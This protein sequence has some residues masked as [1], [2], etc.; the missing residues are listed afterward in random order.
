M[1]M[2]KPR[3]RPQLNLRLAHVYDDGAGIPPDHWSHRFYE[4]I[5]CAFHEEDFADLYEEGGRAP[6]SPTLLACLSLLQ[7]M[8]KVSDRVAV[9]NS[10]MRRD[11]RIALGRLPEYEGFDPSVLCTFRRRLV[12]HEAQRQ[13]FE[14]V[15]QRVQELGLLKGHHRVRVD[16]TE[17]LAD[18]AV[19][20]RADMLREALRLVVCDLA[21]ARPKL[22]R[23]LDFRHLYEQYGAEVWL[24]GGHESDQKVSDLAR[25]GQLLLRLCGP[26]EVAGKETLARLLEENFLFP[27]DQ[28]PIPKPLAELPPDHIAT[29]HE[30][31]AEVGKNDRKIWT[32]DKVHI[33]ET[34]GPGGEPGFVLDVLTTGPRVP[35]AVLLP[36][37]MER[38]RFRFPAVET[39]LAD[40]GYAS[41]ANSKQA[42]ALG[43]DL[44]SPPRLDNTKGILPASAFAFDF[45]RQVATC[46][47]GQ[48][49][50]GWR[51]GRKLHIKFSRPVCRAC[52]RRGECTTSPSEPRTLTLSADYEQL[53]SDRERARRPAFAK[54]YRPRAGVEGTISELVHRCG[55]RRSR[56]R[57]RP[58]RALHSLLSSA[59][60]NVRRLLRAL[61]AGGGPEGAPFRVFS[62]LWGLLRGGFWARPVTSG[63]VLA[64]A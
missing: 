17:L 14:K 54:L 18:V 49:S 55:L 28:D 12:A 30:P 26:Y 34:I 22:R 13:L 56:Y 29:P 51:V 20:S 1:P 10:L 9:D 45:E 52:P 31:D 24:G 32:G 43:L 2:A 27:E 64:A 21:R 5:Y 8:Y 4:Q 60:L 63:G 15:L 40:S 57:S 35:D 58:K 37:I 11:W 16:A 39:I 6:I 44:I 38:L 62:A 59:A 25:D 19:L 46:P 36:E 61:A 47:A 23:R 41:A 42:A 7:Y 33:V 53:L 3:A 48:K 50:V